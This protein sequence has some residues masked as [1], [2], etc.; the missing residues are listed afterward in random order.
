MTN[1]SPIVHVVDDDLSFRSAIGDLL[2]ACGYRVALYKSA[3]Q[4]L[5]SSL[6][7]EPACILLDVKM[8]GMSGTRLQGRLAEL[9]CRL[10]IIFLTGYGDIATS[11]QAIKAGAEDFLT[12]PV[13]KE[14]LLAAIKRA[15]VHCDR[16]REQ[17]SGIATL[18]SL[19]SLLTPREY[20]V[21]AVLVQGRPHKQIAYILG[22]SERT[23]KL[24]RH[25]I[26]Q[27]C[28]VQSL[29]QLAVIAERLG[30]FSAVGSGGNVNFQDAKLA[31]A[32]TFGLTSAQGP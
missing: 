18:R 31:T 29:A 30:L 26:M 23:V 5:E 24:H 13:Q 25:N 14:K 1:L 27:K 19:V 15:L 20:E 32:T 28:R 11:V 4:L 9:G 22:T 3:L 21:F 16:M 6:G 10:P 7:G 8:R 12:K 2:D 17:E